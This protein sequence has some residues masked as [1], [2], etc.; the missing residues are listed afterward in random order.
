MV[1]GD[2]VVQILPVRCAQ[3]CP[4]HRCG[5]CGMGI[6]QDGDHGQ[7]CVYNSS[8]GTRIG[9]D[10][11]KDGAAV[12]GAEGDYGLVDGRVCWNEV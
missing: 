12:S 4:P 5:D 2:G 6:A 10:G 3:G 8:I 11:V 7:R 1:N 9:K